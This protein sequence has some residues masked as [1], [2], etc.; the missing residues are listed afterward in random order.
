[1]LRKSKNIDLLIKGVKAKNLATVGNQKELKC[2]L[3]SH[4]LTRND[5]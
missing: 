5:I 1:M 3:L 4:P 2:H